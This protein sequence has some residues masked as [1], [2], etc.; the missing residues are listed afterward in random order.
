MNTAQSFIDQVEANG[1]KLRVVAGDHLLIEGPI[2]DAPVM[3][4]LRGCRDEVVSIVRGREA[5]TG[6]TK[7]ID[8]SSERRAGWRDFILKGLRRE[9]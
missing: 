6:T 1:G 8:L 4:G 3:D 7:P 9:Q 2:P 5:G